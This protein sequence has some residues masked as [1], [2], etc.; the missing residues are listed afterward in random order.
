MEQAPPPPALDPIAATALRSMKDIVLSA[1]ISWFPQT[2][3]WLLLAALLAAALIFCEFIAIRRYRKNAYRR[4]ALVMLSDIEKHLCRQSALQELALLIKRVSLSTFRRE[5]TGSLSGKDWAKFIEDHSE[6]D[7]RLLG[8]IV[9]DVEYR[10]AVAMDELPAT[11]APELAAD[12][13]R[14]I[15]KHHV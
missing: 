13:R 9:D 2:W 12:A 6:E 11:F 5:K 8:K 14:W 1:P 7:G 4:E 15:E 10:D 3:G